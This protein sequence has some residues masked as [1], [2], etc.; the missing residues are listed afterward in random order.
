VRLEFPEKSE[1]VVCHCGKNPFAQGVAVLRLKPDFSLADRV[2][3]HMQDKTE[4]PVHKILPSP[5]LPTQATF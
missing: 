1:L 5:M 2:I 3:D 4:K